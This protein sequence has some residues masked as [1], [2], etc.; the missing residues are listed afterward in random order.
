MS[1]PVRRCTTGGPGPYFRTHP[2]AY[3]VSQAGS[4]ATALYATVRAV[5]AHGAGRM[6]WVALAMLET[7]IT[8]GIACTRARARRST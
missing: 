8:I 3:R 6:R 4:A 1:A 5:R 7:A 2:I